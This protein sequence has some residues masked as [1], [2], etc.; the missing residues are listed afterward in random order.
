MKRFLVV[1]ALVMFFTLAH[2]QTPVIHLPK[3]EDVFTIAV[4]PVFPEMPHYF[5]PESMQQALPRFKPG[6]A[7]IK[8]GAR[9]FWQSGVIVLK[10]KE[11]LFWSTC[12][13]NFIHIAT[14]TGQ[15]S[16]IIGDGKD[17]L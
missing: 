9:R 5:T 1:T 17:D 7:E 8:V 12:R 15:A 6:Q 14:P 10:N 3:A 16:F 4:H 11:V 13:K 2:A